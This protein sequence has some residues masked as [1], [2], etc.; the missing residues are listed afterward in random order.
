MIEYVN[1]HKSFGRPVLKGITL[2]V[3]AGERLAIVGPSGGGKSVLL[4]TTNG[5]IVP[6]RGDVRIGGESIYF[7]SREILERWRQLTAYVFQHSALFDSMNVFDNVVLGIP[8]QEAKKMGAREKLARVCQALEAVRL[9]PRLVLG[10][11]PSE[12][13]GGMRKR[14]GVARGIVRR[15]H[16][17]L[18][19]EPVTGLDPVTS[20][21]VVRLI[22]RLGRE[23]A[24]TV[25]IVTHDVEGALEFCDRIALLDGGRIR[26]A[27]TPADFRESEDPLVRAFVDRRL[28]AQ[29]DVEVTP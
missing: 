14:V 11:V 16:I 6:D 22:E 12:L 3:R 10:K 17:M 2:T 9:P 23:L 29:A 20:A 5:L 26:F 1:V 8:E 21:A 24:A 28:A 18:F 25:I 7:G 27:G 19:D 15:P 4:K 13:S